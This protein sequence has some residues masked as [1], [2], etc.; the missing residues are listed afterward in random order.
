MNTLTNLASEQRLSI[1]RV[2]DLAILSKLAANSEV[3]NEL[4]WET[5]APFARRCLNR[6][7]L[8]DFLSISNALKVAHFIVD[9]NFVE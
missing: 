9:E 8:I 3:Q 5:L 6:A 4:F 7:S 2:S 1:F